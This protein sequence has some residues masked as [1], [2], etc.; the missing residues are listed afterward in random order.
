MTNEFETYKTNSLVLCEKLLWELKKNKEDA[1][2]FFGGEIYKSY[3]DATDNAKI[4]TKN[5]QTKIRNI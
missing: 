1:V 3:I 4:E 2:S 5:I